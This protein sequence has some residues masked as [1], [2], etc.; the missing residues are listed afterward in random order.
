MKKYYLIVLAALAL[1]C[2]CEQEE[3]FTPNY[4]TLCSFTVDNYKVGD[5]I[6]FERTDGQLDT[7][8]VKIVEQELFA[9]SASNL[10]ESSKDGNKYA[11]V[12]IK[13][14]DDEGDDGWYQL[15]I[16]CTLHYQYEYLLGGEFTWKN[17]LKYPSFDGSNFKL[18]SLPAEILRTEDATITFAELKKGEGIIRFGDKDGEIWAL[19]ERL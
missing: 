10:S 3:L 17:S 11:E 1:F 8:F 19:K 6:V 9:S 2:S 13:M 4:E 12:R 16:N 15:I 5:V 14:T 7:F 18:N